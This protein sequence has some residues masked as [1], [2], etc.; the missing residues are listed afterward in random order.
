M[1][2]KITIPNVFTPNADG[3]NDLFEI[4][5]SGVTDFNLTIYNRW[6]QIVFE[7][8][9]PNVYWDGQTPAGLNAPEGTYYYILKGS[10]ESGS[11][12]NTEGYVTLLR[13]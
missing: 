10:F 6:G 11:L 4:D 5:Y 1:L 3:K 2:E 12:I 8:Q 9:N 7:T 13:N